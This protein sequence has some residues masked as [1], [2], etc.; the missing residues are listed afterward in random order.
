[1]GDDKGNALGYQTVQLSLSPED[2]M[3]EKKGGLQ[4]DPGYAGP[5]WKRKPVVG[6]R[7]DP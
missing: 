3:I 5:Q 2:G 7:R 6:F 4:A 1:V